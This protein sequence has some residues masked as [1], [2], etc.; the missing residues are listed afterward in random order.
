MRFVRTG[1]VLVEENEA[2]CLVTAT[3]FKWLAKD[4][5]PRR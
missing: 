4:E 3:G 1:D 2:V 5:E